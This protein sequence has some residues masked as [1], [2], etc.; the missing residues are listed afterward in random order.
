MASIN[1]LVRTQNYRRL[2][3]QLET[4]N[5][6]I[7]EL[8]RE[9]ATSKKTSDI[10]AEKAS[11]FDILA[12]SLELVNKVHELNA[13]SDPIGQDVE[14]PEVFFDN[15]MHQKV[16]K[17]SEISLAPV[18]GEDNKFSI[19]AE[20]AAEEK[21]FDASG[22]QICTFKSLKL[23]VATLGEGAYKYGD[24]KE[25]ADGITSEYE[26]YFSDNFEA[27]STH[28]R[29]EEHPTGFSVS[30]GPVLIKF[31][32]T[33]APSL[34]EL[35]VDEIE[36]FVDSSSLFVGEGSDDWRWFVM[37]QLPLRDGEHQDDEKDLT[38]KPIPG[39]QPTEQ[40]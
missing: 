20:L 24:L 27:P 34:G 1:N 2:A 40:P 22:K 13:F 37:L 18:D 10:S 25:F 29:T 33:G 6:R 36:A 7:A 19:S 12:D 26:T 35:D 15:K 16:L 17:V 28:T 39:E 38:L 8:E 32:S 31:P 23:G 4:R 3:A 11:A 14:P 21:I 30:P 5:S 9:L